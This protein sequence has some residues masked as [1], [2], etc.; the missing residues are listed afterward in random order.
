MSRAATVLYGT[1]TAKGE[2]GRP[3]KQKKSAGG[4]GDSPGN[5]RL[6]VEANARAE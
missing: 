3:Q 2:D 1:A 5:D 6:A 4:F